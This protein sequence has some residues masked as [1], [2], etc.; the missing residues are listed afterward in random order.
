MNG[1]VFFKIGSLWLE[2]NSRV[3]LVC[4]LSICVNRNCISA[5]A[6]VHDSNTLEQTSL[7]NKF[8]FFLSSFCSLLVPDITFLQSSDSV[9]SV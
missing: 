6:L 8:C 3:A 9:R 2:K 5:V 7:G 1:K 4:V